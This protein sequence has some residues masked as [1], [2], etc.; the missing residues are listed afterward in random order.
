MAYAIGYVVSLIVFGIIDAAW[1]TAMAN[2]LYR[3]TLGDLMLDRLRWV[4]ALLFYFGFPLG[5]VYFAV[6]PGF[7]ADSAALAIGNGAFLGLLAYATYDLTNFAT[8]KAWT[9]QITLA[10]I[11]YGTVTVAVVSAA[12]YFA[13]KTASGW[14]WI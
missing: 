1:L 7:R 3:P 5:I 6:M 4:P 14:G 11:A 8:L 9:L 12:A 13:L 10:D 2:T